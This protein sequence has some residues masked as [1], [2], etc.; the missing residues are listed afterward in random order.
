MSL[1]AEL[2]KYILSS[3]LISDFDQ[4]FSGNE[5]VFTTWRWTKM[6]RMNLMKRM[7][8]LECPQ[9]NSTQVSESPPACKL[10]WSLVKYCAL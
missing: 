10:D 6:Q 8:S 2:I 9:V 5:F 1:S 3:S 4:H 7:R